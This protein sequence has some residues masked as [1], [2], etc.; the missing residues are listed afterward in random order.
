MLHAALKRGLERIRATRHTFVNALLAE[1]S[2]EVGRLYEAVHPGEGLQKISLSLDEKRRASLDLSTRFQAS[3]PAPPQAYFSDS[4][5]DTLGLCVFLALA[6]RRSPRTNV[7]VLDDVLA[8]VDEP[9]VDRL[10]EMIYIEAQHFRHVVVTTHYRPWREKLRW[11]WLKQGQ[12]QLVE[13]GRWSES[14]PSLVRS[15]GEIERLRQVLT[16][17]DFDGQTACAK[18]GVVLEAVLDFLTDLYQC[19]LPRKPRND[20]TLGDLIPAIGK[21]LRSALHVEVHDPGDATGYKSHALGPLLDDL[22][23]I[24]QTRNLVGA[25]FNKLAFELLDTDAERFARKVLE[26][27][28]RLVDAEHGWPRSNK[29]GSYWAT[30]SDAR[31]LHPLQTPG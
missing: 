15:T 16:N 26:L 17:P 27:A 21:K 2:E 4:H 6:K 14:G 19:K 31:R 29:S 20:W 3:A 1:I 23:K 10:I 9:H 8:S 13:L 22:E 12:C 11:G 30:A 7:L 24:A 5:L 25:H 28:E 18:A